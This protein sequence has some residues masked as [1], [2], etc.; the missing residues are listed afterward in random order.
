MWIKFNENESKEE[1]SGNKFICNFKNLFYAG[2]VVLNFKI[3]LSLK[4]D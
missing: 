3:Q 4:V 2:L 1:T